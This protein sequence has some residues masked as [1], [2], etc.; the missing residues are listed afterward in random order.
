MASTL[1]SLSLGDAELEGWLRRI[2]SG[3]AYR[4]WPTPSF[5][6]RVAQFYFFPANDRGSTI[7]IS[8]AHE[9]RFQPNHQA[10]TARRVGRLRPG[11]PHLRVVTADSRRPILIGATRRLMMEVANAG[12]ELRRMG[13]TYT[14]G[15][16]GNEA[17]NETL[18]EVEQLELLATLNPKAAVARLGRVP[19]DDDPIAGAAARAESDHRWGHVLADLLIEEKFSIDADV[20]RRMIRSARVF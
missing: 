13:V 14:V 19:A 8:A 12:G 1:E 11:R 10:V 17:L 7:E 20:I 2:G 15:R 4:S 18:V 9:L 3:T 6:S 16:G 5:W